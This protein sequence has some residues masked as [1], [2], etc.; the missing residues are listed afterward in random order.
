MKESKT[1]GQKIT[2]KIDSRLRKSLTKS[3][4]RLIRK[5]ELESDEAEKKTLEFKILEKLGSRIFGSGIDLIAGLTN[6]EFEAYC[7]ELLAPTME[8]SNKI[9]QERIRF[10]TIMREPLTVMAE[11]RG[12][13]DLI[14]KMDKLLEFEIPKKL[15][16]KLYLRIIS[17]QMITNFR[18]NISLARFNLLFEILAITSKRL[19]VDETW[20]F[21]NLALDLE[22]TLIKKKLSQLSVGK[23]ELKKMSYETILD[24]VV[25]LIRK[26][27]HRSIPLELYTSSG[28]RTVRHLVT[29][30]G[31]HYAPTRE[32]CSDIVS[33]MIKVERALW[34]P[35]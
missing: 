10:E 24:K 18:N 33:H 16:K 6:K 13:E 3:D 26:T 7:E 35:N 32:E 5:Y 4:H 21:S 19:Q 17:L 8:V 20:A 30:E 27:E 12:Y 1:I 15:E 9:G 31:Y 22:E 29:H 14:K 25:K 34:P 23:N 11:L 2:K 28:Y